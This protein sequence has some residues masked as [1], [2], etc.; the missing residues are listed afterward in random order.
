GMVS[1]RIDK[2]DTRPFSCVWEGQRQQSLGLFF[3]SQGRK[4]RGQTG[5]VT[6]ILNVHSKLSR[7]KKRKHNREK[8][9]F[10]DGDHGSSSLKDE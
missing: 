8:A 3:S 10:R 7:A 5:T 2:F 9:F 6:T 4:N 1:Q